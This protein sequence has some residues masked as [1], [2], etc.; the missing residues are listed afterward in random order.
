MR[1][2]YGTSAENV[3]KRN[4]TKMRRRPIAIGEINGGIRQEW[5]QTQI[6]RG[7]HAVRIEHVRSHTG[8]PGNELADRL[9]DAGM[10]LDQDDPDAPY[11][12]DSEMPIREM[13]GG[14]AKTGREATHQDQPPCGFREG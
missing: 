6:R 9:A 12:L 11:G 8:V 2:A 7:R 4:R 14:I 13:M 5:R 3:R 1:Y 10:Q